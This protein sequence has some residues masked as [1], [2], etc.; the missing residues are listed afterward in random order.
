[1]PK[2]KQ[3]PPKADAVS[4]VATA[5]TDTV[6]G[7]N[8]T[9]GVY[10]AQD[11][12][13]AL[14]KRVNVAIRAATLR[15]RWMPYIVEAVGE[16]RVKPDGLYTELALHLVGRY[17]REVVAHQWPAKVQGAKSKAWAKAM[18]EAYPVVEAAEVWVME[19]DEPVDLAVIDEPQTTDI[20]LKQVDSAAAALAAVRKHLEAEKA[21][22][23]DEVET[24]AAL[25]A[26]AAELARMHREVE[27]Q[28]DELARIK[29][30]QAAQI[31]EDELRANI[32]AQM[33]KPLGK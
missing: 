9:E 33:G 12:A 20:Q 25:Q 7:Q 24:N 14:E 17:Y 22:L 10:T 15:S 18:R 13:S 1:M 5:Q 26:E 4:E 8:D 2:A 29:A 21:A 19:D 11:L 27:I 30:E 16:S 23:L 28:R 32:R 31:E 3:N 6:S